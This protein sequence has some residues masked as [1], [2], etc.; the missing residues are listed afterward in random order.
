M[1]IS[2]DA[3]CIYDR[4][5]RFF[6]FFFLRIAHKNH[7]CKK[8]ASDQYQSSM[9]IWPLIQKI[10]LFIAQNNAIWCDMKFY[11]HLFFQH[12]AHLLCQRDH[13]WGEGICIS[14]VGKQP[15]NGYHDPNLFWFNKTSQQKNF[16][17]F[18]I[19]RLLSVFCSEQDLYSNLPK[20]KFNTSK[21]SHS[22]FSAI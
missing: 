18:T 2:K 20:N 19:D 4:N 17:Y 16:E 10:E 15:K 3:Q 13:F 5:Y 7:F 12:I 14:L 22:T 1:F 8:W 6:E 9:Q 21:N 11:A